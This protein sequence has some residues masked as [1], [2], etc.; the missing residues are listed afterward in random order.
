MRGKAIKEF[1][2]MVT[3]NEARKMAG[4][5]EMEGPEGEEMYAGFTQAVVDNTSSSSD[6]EQ[7]Y[8]D[9]WDNAGD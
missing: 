7:K 5:P 3:V 1:A 8:D 9:W 6:D 2:G 4:L